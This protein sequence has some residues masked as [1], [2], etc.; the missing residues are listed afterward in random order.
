MSRGR[1]LLIVLASVLV[2][3]SALSHAIVR[4][5][6]IRTSGIDRGRINGEAAGKPALVLGSSLTFFGI[7]FR[8]VAKAMERPLVTR[9][10]GG[11]SPC[12]LEWLVPEVPEA[13]R[14]I[15][16]ISIFDLNESNLS[17]SR[18]TLVPF[19][20]T[21]SD[22]RAS[23][24]DWTSMKRV[25]WSYPVPWIQHIL[26]V[27]GRSNA[28]MVNLRDKVRSLRK[29]AA[30]V[31]LEAKLTFKTDEDSGRPEKL[32]DWDGGRIARNLSQLSATGLAHGRFDG[33][34]SLA[35][36]RMIGR[37]AQQEPMLVIV[38]PVSPPYR[39]AFADATSVEHFEKALDRIKAANPTL[40]MIRLDQEP[41]LQP[42]E[43]YWDLVHLNDDGR[44]IATRRVIEQLAPR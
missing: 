33:P 26:P 30:N 42:A 7:S 37:A 27:A 5:L 19:T 14:T 40:Q 41:A 31:D 8:E 4:V 22:L 16:G 17:D 43:V 23:H 2:L 34:K 38:I 36:A 28:V 20:Q 35:L 10:V 6:D 21:I 39:E 1:Q 9:G 18:P 15:I 11:C 32:S 44:R 24:S 3:S 13:T 29:Q 25:V 12:E